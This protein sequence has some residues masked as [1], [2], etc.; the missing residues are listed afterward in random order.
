MSTKERVG[1]IIGTA[2]G[3][4]LLVGIYF[5]VLIMV[6]TDPLLILLTG[7]LAVLCLLVKLSYEVEMAAHEE[8]EQR[9]FQREER[10]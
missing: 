6:L 10:L 1:L 8:Y 9:I 5:C 4:M 3:V 2:V 7:C